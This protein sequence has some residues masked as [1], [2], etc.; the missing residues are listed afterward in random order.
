[1]S[2]VPEK[3]NHFLQKYFLVDYKLKIIE[4]LYTKGGQYYSHE[5]PHFKKFEAEGRTDWK[6]KKKVYMSTNGLFSPPKI[7][8]EQKK[9]YAVADVLFFTDIQRGAK[10]KEKK[11]FGLIHER[12]SSASAHEPHKVVARA[13]L[14]PPLVYTVIQVLV[15]Y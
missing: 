3:M 14:C 11:V 9:I 2:S 10:Q 6:S 4:I 7:G 8:E 1:M 15:Y 5:G 13:A 12:S